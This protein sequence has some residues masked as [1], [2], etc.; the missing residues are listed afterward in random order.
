MSI[1]TSKTLIVKRD[2]K[3][4]FPKEFTSRELIGKFFDYIMNN[5]FEKNYL[6]FINGY[7]G[8]KTQTLEDGNFYIKEPTAE[9]QL[10]QLEPMLITK[11]EDNNI[12]DIIDYVSFINSLKLQ[13]SLTNDHNRLLS[14]KHWSFCPPIDVDMFLNYNFYYWIEE[15]VKPIYLTNTTN[16]VKDII[17]KSQ[18]TYEYDNEE[19]EHILIPFYNGMRIIFRSDANYEYNNK[20]YI[21]EGV[22]KE[23]YLV[24]DSEIYNP[25]NDS[26]P[27]YF[28]MDRG[29]IDA[30]P[31]SLRNRWFHIDDIK[32]ANIYNQIENDNTKYVQA[33]KPILC[34]NKDIELYNFGKHD[35]GWV[36]IITK[37][38]KSEING[39]IINKNEHDGKLLLDGVYVGNNAKILFTNE[40]NEDSNNMI[41]EL[42]FIENDE[43]NYLLS[44][45][46]VVNG[47][48]PDG[49][50]LKYDC[51]KVKNQ[52]NHCY[53]FNGSEW[54][55]SQQKTQLC[56]S[57][58]FNLYDKNKTL[59]NDNDTYPNSTFNGNTLFDYKSSD[60]KE[61]N[62][63]NDI[64]RRLII[65]DYGNYVFDN[66]IISKT[67]AYKE[68][69]SSGV[70][71]KNIEGYNYYK[72]IDKDEYK[73]CW[74]LSNDKLTQ[75]V[76]T[77]ITVENN[78]EFFTYIDEKNL[79]VE[80]EVFDIAY[81][82]FEN[83]Y[84][85]NIF[86]YLNGEILEKGDDF[87]LG[88]FVVKGKKLY[89]SLKTGLK[90]YDAL[91]IKIL[92]D[93]VDE[94]ADG[95]VFDL[96]QMLS[97]NALNE[98]ITEIKYNEMF[99]Q[100]HSILK[101]QLNFEGL[102]NGINNYKDTLKDLSL[103]TSI[104]QHSTPILKTMLLNSKEYT[105]IRNVLSNISLDYT[106][107]K[108]KFTN[109]I[110]NMSENNE[111]SEYIKSEYES[112]SDYYKKTDPL[113]IVIKILNKINI[114]KE[115]LK[116]YF[117]NGVADQL[118]NLDDEDENY[119]VE[120][121]IPSTPAYL[122]LDNC[123]KPQIIYPLSND[124]R[125]KVLLCHDGSYQNLFNDYRDE[126]Y[127]TLENAIYD[128]INI[129]FKEGLPIII[130]QKYMPGKFRNTD[131]SYD[132][133]LKMYTPFFEKWISKYG[134]DYSVNNTFNEENTFTWNWSSCYDKDGFKLPGSYRAIYVYYYDTDK[135]H[136]NPWEMLG[137]GNKPSWW[138]EHY[139]SA[140]Y[141]S[142]NIPMWKDIEEGHII[143]GIS[144][145]YYNEFKRPGLIENFL[146]VD[147][148]GNLK[149]PYQAGIATKKPILK[150]AR[151]PWK[152]G[153]FGYIENVW[154][155]TSE[156]RYDMQTLLY[157][158]KPLEWLETSWDSINTDTLFKGTDNEQ[159]I[160]INSGI[161]DIQN[162]IIMHNEYI[163]NNYV[164]KLGSQQW[165]SDFLTS[166]SI[167]ITDY[168]GNNLRS[169]NL[170]L[171]YRCA[172]YFDRD[173]IKVISDNYGVIPSANYQ[174]KLN[175]KPTGN[176]F[177]YSA[178]II[179]KLPEGWLIDGFD[180][181]Y[182]Y[183]N[184]FKPI[185]NDK[186][187][188]IE[189]NGRNFTYYNTYFDE[190]TSIRYKSI[191]TS[192]Q[193]VYN[194][195][196]G[197][198]KYLESI[199]F[200]FNA[201]GDEGEQVDFRYDGKKFLLWYDNKNVEDGS[202][203]LIN[204][205]RYGL[206]L[207][208]NSFVDIV[209][210]FFNG[211]WAAK[212]ISPANIYNKDISIYRHNGYIQ[213]N[214]KNDDEIGSIKFTTSEKE[215][216]LLIDNKTI[217]GDEIYNSLKGT[218]TERL[219]L[220]GTKTNG[221]NGTYYTPG[222]IIKEESIVPDYDKL[223]D[224]LI[225]VYD[226]D[227]IRSF[228]SMGDESK[229]T[230]GFHKTNYMENL[231]IDNRNMFDFYKG[232]LKE[233]GTRLSFN[234]LNR[235]T[236][237]MSEGSSKL[238][239]DEFW[240]F[241]IGQFGYTKN[242]STLEFLINA[243]KITHDPQIITFSSDPNYSSNDYSNIF[244][245]WNDKKWLKKY[246]NQDRSCFEY[247]DD[248]K[249]LP[250]G[251]FAQLD[252]CKY[253]LESKDMMENEVENIDIN[254][255]I[256]IVKDTEY[257]WNMY[258][259]I[260][261]NDTP[262]K[263]LKVNNIS[264][265]LSYDNNYLN[266]GDLI[267]VEK[268][269]LS[270][271]ITSLS[272]NN[273]EK[274]LNLYINDV[275][276]LLKNQNYITNDYGWSV[277]KYNLLPY[278]NI[279]SMPNGIIS[280]DK[281]TSSYLPTIKKEVIL[282]MP[283]GKENNINSYMEYT[284]KNDIPINLSNGKYV[285]FEVRL[286]N[287][288]YVEKY[289]ISKSFVKSQAAP[290]SNR[291]FW[292]NPDS[293]LFSRWN[294][295]FWENSSTI[296]YAWK[297]NKT[298]YYTLEKNPKNTSSVYSISNNIVTKTSYTISQVINKKYAW[299]F[300]NIIYY[301][302][303]E[304]PKSGDKIYGSNR[305]SVEDIISSYYDGSDY[306]YCDNKK[307]VRQPSNDYNPTIKI[308]DDEYIS[309]DNYNRNSPYF[310]LLS[311]I[312]TDKINN[313]YK[314]IDIKISNPY[315]LER[316]EQ[317]QININLIDTV[318]L[319]DNNTDIT[320]S[321]AY[322]YD[323]LHCV[324][325]DFISKELDY[326]TSYDPVNYNNGNNW[327]DNKVGRLWWDTSKVRYIDYYQGSLKYRRDNW[328][329][330]LPGSEIDI[331]EWTKS[332]VLPDDVEKYVT[333]EVF[334][335]KTNKNDIYYYYWLKN[336]SILPDVDFRNTTAYDISRKINSPQDENIVWFSPI[337]LVNRVYDDS[338][339]IIGNFDSLTASHD[340]V[341]QINFK[342]IN[343]VDEHNEWFM[344]VENS[345]DK[346][347]ESLWDKMKDSL[348]GEKII[349]GNNFPIPDPLL[350]EQEKYGISIRPR[351]TMFKNIISARRNFV[352]ICNDIFSSR[353]ILTSSTDDINKILLKDTSYENY[354]YI[355]SF[356]SHQQMILSRDKSLLNQ[357]VLVTNDE[358]YDGIWTLWKIN[359]FSDYELIDYQKYDMNRYVYFI[360]AFFNDDYSKDT[361]HKKIY[362]TNYDQEISYLKNKGIPNG[363]IIRVDDKETRDWLYLEQYNE[364]TG[365]FNIVGVRN[366][367]I[368][369]NDLLYSFMEN[370]DENI[371]I[372]NETNYDYIN[373][374]SKKIIE[375]LC[376]Y[377]EER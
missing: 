356:T 110:E 209:G 320:L 161:R 352:D 238:N 9:R 145:G 43:G 337:N 359:S 236:H 99:D 240:A 83:Q 46:P 322:M 124:L 233:K 160:N 114:G 135:P 118:I 100:C 93:K 150:Y 167:N 277:F 58:L 84:K 342:N 283:I 357:N 148:E 213:V 331:M 326:I 262:F 45:Y 175:S 28:V 60:N 96:P 113:S 355:D 177:R 34:F 25:Y 66:T 300:N 312:Q 57:P 85:E 332:T 95:Y 215:N 327:V 136:T 202:L 37:T 197:Y 14:N 190:I 229:K 301:T 122:G 365:T 361:Y 333:K 203:L 373:N 52:I 32:N 169:M 72:I 216:I 89:V 325:P 47:K 319:V 11:D 311:E 222:Y 284:I 31:W 157:L 117:N 253:I 348:I 162:D 292:Y 235:S 22:N 138:E 335:P 139:G 20:P 67:Y 241:K 243:D 188:S 155:Y 321:K 249:K 343:D 166:E 230:I 192:P 248:N 61:I 106:K 317:K 104:L 6:R 267:Y 350:S 30:N 68:I 29:C 316:V 59:L 144:E 76:I 323:P 196:C 176:V 201:I 79:P 142:E 170:Q 368:Q 74:H 287:D 281:L 208:H 314:L 73:N 193:E 250:S 354:N 165:F 276:K 71:L 56:Q 137:F 13:G 65:S 105:N 141:T 181:E 377:F 259:R 298:I 218:K 39:K 295:A 294:G 185:K 227:N 123:Y 239:L 4:I 205:M 242:K 98:N 363:F 341:T 102:V 97:S 297:F 268:D 264:E 130:K 364:E 187:S 360:D 94:L 50:A 103:G 33:K 351:Q 299:K 134:I 7:I 195:L 158:L 261:N 180:D 112:S 48:D 164:R 307:Y 226:S 77:E 35:R 263:S 336:P 329:K 51:I 221:W 36:D 345:D 204:P 328:G 362:N 272:D 245:N 246:N 53:Y 265:L 128:S 189:I 252:D 64:K 282:D 258:K 369:L 271:W 270:D 152:I 191:I 2:L 232:V 54:V 90:E 371:F 140:P 172:G 274:I 127:I 228:G 147:E 375:I 88:T 107:F 289:Y 247:I 280:I 133:Y 308:Y 3:Q 266:D 115:G 49:K 24:D 372:N 305:T 279:K 27:E 275:N 174:L 186:K 338:S 121:Y 346:I 42:S 219:K 19:G 109:I 223:A 116:P 293:N 324:L 143:D 91:F 291:E 163:N 313:V 244:I 285:I 344:I 198:E 207:T 309:N 178:V 1:K 269:N 182:P 159:I 340:F 255:K 254:D 81:K 257:T 334:N 358:L 183:F 339:F 370:I 353:N 260:D 220:L 78:R 366:G 44:L 120:P 10:Y 234:K 21:V 310:C 156:Y 288:E 278:S 16:A 154:R 92:V 129:R 304:A 212:N 151:E 224:D 273:D 171:G 286:S 347:P 318:Y 75:Y 125:K 86:V 290:T 225:Y 237:I 108:N 101:N 40:P 367:F 194:I 184:I 12:E 15:G 149:D 374:E 131:Y 26:E 376:N 231:L 126:A 302:D 330:Q 210:K 306:L 80:Y 200:V 315:S 211:Q 87:G 146:P 132:E 82:P 17:G 217:Y 206:T 55:C 23:I 296:L 153:D 168:I 5:F 119:L 349:N 8:R 251:G 38:P 173:T 303:S 69:T 70:L 18:Y 41:Y 179:Q 199:G 111:Y 214:T 62:Y 256:W 63:D